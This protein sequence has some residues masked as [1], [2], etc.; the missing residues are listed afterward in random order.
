MWIGAGILLA[1]AVFS[2]VV[3]YFWRTIRELEAVRVQLQQANERLTR[4]A[5]I[6]GLTGIANRR[7]FDETLALEVRRSQREGHPLS[8]ILCD[9][10]SFKPYND[11]YGHARGDDTLKRVAQTV[12]KTFRRA[13]D[14]AARYGGEEFAIILPGIDGKQAWLFADRLRRNVWRLAIHNAGSTVADRVT[15]SAGV[16]TTA[17]GCIY[18]ADE[19]IEA[20]DAALYLAKDNGRNR[21]ESHRP[22]ETPQ[23]PEVK[24]RTG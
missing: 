17:P 14:L 12:E 13:G 8:L 23:F 20:A 15:L 10:D 7:H 21:V 11:S 5:S 19:L 3:L 18:A 2:V 16:A 6:D 24:A 22:P 1:A 9:I 4:L